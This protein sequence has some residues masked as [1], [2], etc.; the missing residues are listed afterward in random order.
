MLSADVHY[1]RMNKMT[2]RGCVAAGQRH[3]AAGVGASLANRIRMSITAERELTEALVLV[4]IL[5]LVVAEV[6]LV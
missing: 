5:D 6:P 4:G 2:S 3:G 1:K